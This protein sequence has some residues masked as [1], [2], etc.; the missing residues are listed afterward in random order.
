MKIDNSD[1]Y[2]TLK[3]IIKNFS[4]SLSEDFSD[5]FF[6]SYFA[7]CNKE[8]LFEQIKRIVAVTLPTL[9]EMTLKLASVN[10]EKRLVYGVVLEPDTFDA[11]GDIISKEEVESAAHDYLISSRLVGDQHVKEAEAAPVESYIAHSDLDFQ[12][13]LV[14]EGSWVMVVKVESDKLW[15]GIKD[16]TYNSFSIGALAIREDYIEPKKK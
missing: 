2:W 13:S 3:T 16:K 10:D 1:Q 6:I 11:H 8:K 14:K 4:Q 9:S 15:K 5:D 12:G 7:L